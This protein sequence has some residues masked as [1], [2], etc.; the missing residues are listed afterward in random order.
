MPALE[1]IV[2]SQM[3]LHC[4][5]HIGRDVL[6]GDRSSLIAADAGSPGNGPGRC[7][8][9]AALLEICVVSKRDL[10]QDRACPASSLDD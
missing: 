1:A 7:H 5:R 9:P 10:R 3:M 6:I 4:S 2:A 8:D